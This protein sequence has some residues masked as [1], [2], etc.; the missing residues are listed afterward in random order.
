M[1]KISSASVRKME[2]KSSG[3]EDVK[4]RNIEAAVRFEGREFL[5]FMGSVFASPLNSFERYEKLIEFVL[6][7]FAY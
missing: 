5:M 2:E 7:I 3:E 6:I 4:E 1:K